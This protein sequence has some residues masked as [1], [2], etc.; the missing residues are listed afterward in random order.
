MHNGLKWLA[1]L[2][3]LYNSTTENNFEN[4][5]LLKIFDHNNFFMA[6]YAYPD[7]DFC[8]FRHFPHE[9]LVFPVIYTDRP[10]KCTCTLIALTQHMY[11]YLSVFT[12]F[13]VSSIP[14]MACQ[15]NV[16]H[17]S[18]K[19]VTWRKNSKL[20]SKKMPILLSI[21]TVTFSK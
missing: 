9:R 14:K 17:I 4:G 18:E 5:L 12:E 13:N 7:R 20:V 6:P 15:G 16:S 19:N 10:L 11:E 8:L 3:G 2:K 21:Q 1:H